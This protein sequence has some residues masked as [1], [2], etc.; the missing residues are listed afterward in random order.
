MVILITGKKD[1]GKTTYGE[2]L[3]T[4]L[5]D[6]GISVAMIDGDKYRAEKGT[7]GKEHFTDEA[8]VKNLM[9]AAHLAAQLEAEGK[10]VIVAFVAPKKG[11][12][13]RMRLCWKVSRVVYVPGGTL[14]A[15]TTYDRPDDD[16]INIRFNPG[17]S[18]PD[19]KNVDFPLEVV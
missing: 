6:E 9:G 7:T 4:E 16:E 2:R 11:W 18:P 10:V 14:W 8:R 13:D 17:N 5:R 15:G 19:N 3:S 12:R 1:S